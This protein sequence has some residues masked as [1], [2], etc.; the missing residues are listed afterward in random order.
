MARIILSAFADEYS[1]SFTEQLEALRSFD[2]GYVEMRGVDGKNVSLLTR[3]EVKEAKIK[4]DHYGIGVSAMGSPIGKIKLD[5]DI[6]GHFEMAKRVFESASELGAKYIRMFSF[7]APEGKSILDC[8]AEVLDRLSALLD[9]AKSHGVLLCHE[10]EAE[11]YGSV[12][13]RCREI[14][15]SFSGQIKTVFDMG[16]YVLEGVKPYT[17]GYGMLKDSIAYFHIKDALAAGA[18][19]P[20]GKGEASI[21]EILADHVRYAK[22]DFF[23]SIEP[24]LQLFSGLN[25]LV[26]RKFE[27][28]YKYNDQKE[29]FTDAVVKLKEILP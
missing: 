1:N 18:I 2:I 14:Y 7:Y 11:I 12:P 28:P 23:V 5:G 21:R 19:V 9:L 29:A 17:E 22:D 20:P 15:D 8:R 25:A 13:E 10:N 16:N 3:D 4:L 26:G 27:N 6:C 24:H